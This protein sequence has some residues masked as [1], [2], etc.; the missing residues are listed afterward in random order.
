MGLKSKILHL[1]NSLM[2]DKKLQRLSEKI[3]QIWQIILSLENDFLEYQGRINIRRILKLQLYL[4]LIKVKLQ[5]KILTL[6][7]QL[8]ALKPKTYQ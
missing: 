4:L 5:R 8:I 6:I 2:N 3:Q 1:E 7:Q